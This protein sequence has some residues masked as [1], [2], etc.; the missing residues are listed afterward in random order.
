MKAEA[1]FLT[2]KLARSQVTILQQSSRLLYCCTIASARQNPRYHIWRTLDTFTS[3][4]APTRSIHDFQIRLILR[5]GIHDPL[6][7]S[8][9]N[10]LASRS[11]APVKL[12]ISNITAAC[13]C[14]TSAKPMALGLL[15]SSA[16]LWLRSRTATAFCCVAATA[17][18]VSWKLELG[19]VLLAVAGC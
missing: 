12:L 9:S 19:R 7:T 8:P 13:D 16:S 2:T 11:P 17:L 1:N 15:S 4:S 6:L 14:A 5:H 3:P 10:M 18:W